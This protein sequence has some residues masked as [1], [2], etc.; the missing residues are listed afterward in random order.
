MTGELFFFRNLMKKLFFRIA[1][2]FTVVSGAFMPA[3]VHAA[4]TI[5]FSEGQRK[6]LRELSNRCAL[7]IHN[8]FLEVTNPNTLVNAALN[9]CNQH[10]FS[11]AEQEVVEYLVTSFHTEWTL[12]TTRAQMKKELLDSIGYALQNSALATF[13]DFNTVEKKLRNLKEEFV[14]MLTDPSVIDYNARVTRMDR[15]AVDIY[16]KSTELL[17]GHVDRETA[18]N[19]LKEALDSV[20]LANYPAADRTIQILMGLLASLERERPTP[21]RQAPASL[22]HNEE[23][24][25]SSCSVQ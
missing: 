24:W 2:S 14:E 21:R 8:A 1:I 11:P 22:P 4:Q 19:A 20:V 18:I 10:H 25:L 7:E 6:W 9:F 17:Y 13:P 3:S 16:R 5:V 15:V 12:C 23:N